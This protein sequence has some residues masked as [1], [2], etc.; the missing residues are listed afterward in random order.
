MVVGTNFRF[1]RDR[2][3]DVGTLRAEGTRHG[4]EVDAVELLRGEGTP[5]SSSV[6]RRYL[7]AGDVEAAE[8]ALSR[9][10]ELRGMVVGG[11]GRGHA[12]GYPTANLSFDTDLAVPAR[13]VYAAMVRV[14][15]A[16]HPA[17]VNV[18][19]RPT[20]G[21]DELTVEA[22]LLD[23]GGD[24]YGRMVAILFRYRLREERRFEAID[25]L[26]AQI[27]KDA[28]ASRRLLSEGVNGGLRPAT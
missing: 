6:I 22:H 28:S 18:G 19:V 16:I 14:A 11:D 5:V 25:E 3:G 12:L 10:F 24:L 7:A 8:E 26:V 20:F 13:G 4:F 27:G 2:V 23:F 9:P 15:G 1:G 17:V 21:G